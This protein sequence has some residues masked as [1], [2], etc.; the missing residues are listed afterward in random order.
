MKKA[1]PDR[2]RTTRRSKRSRSPHERAL[3][4]SGVYLESVRKKKFLYVRVSGRTV[5]LRKGTRGKIRTYDSAEQFPTAAK[6]LEA[7]IAI[8]GEHAKSGFKIA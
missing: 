8:L 5:C 7:A 2:E 4:G 6:A 3:L 1:S